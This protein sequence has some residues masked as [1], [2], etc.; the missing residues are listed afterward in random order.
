M[1][2]AIEL[3]DEKMP[4]LDEVLP[5][6]EDKECIADLMKKYAKLIAE[7]VRDEAAQLAADLHEE[8]SSVIYREI[9]SLEIQTP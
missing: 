6:P 3:L 1:K 5:M 7:D 8:R 4:W 2:Q 9:I